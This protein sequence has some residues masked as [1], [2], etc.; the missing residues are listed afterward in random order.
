MMNGGVAILISRYI[1]HNMLC[2]KCFDEGQYII[3]K[4][5]DT[6]LCNVYI[7]PNVTADDLF[8]C[9]LLGTR[10]KSLHRVLSRS[11]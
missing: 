5:A 3:T 7:R 4:V 9:L 1:P 10:V 6:L 11:G 2:S 8:E